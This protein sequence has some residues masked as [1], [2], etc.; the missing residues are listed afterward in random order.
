M[1]RLWASSAWIQ[2]SYDE[3][4]HVAQLRTP[5]HTHKNYQNIV[6]DRI[7]LCL[8]M[9]RVFQT[10]S[11]RHVASISN[12]TQNPFVLVSR[13]QSVNCPVIAVGFA[14]PAVWLWCF[15][16]CFLWQLNATFFTAPIFPK[17][18]YIMRVPSP[19]YITMFW[20]ELQRTHFAYDDSC[21]QSTWSSFT[22]KK[23]VITCFFLFVRW[24]VEEKRKKHW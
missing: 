10:L 21:K 18:K 8:C 15:W 1:L 2:G 16:A 3:F 5:S 24:R 22:T 17:K 20:L 23:W 9:L 4:R 13:C 19:Y 11:W 12:Q 7:L 6:S 14:E